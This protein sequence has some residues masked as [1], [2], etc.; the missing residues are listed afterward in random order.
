[1]TQPRTKSTKSRAPRND[2]AAS[3]RVDDILL[4]P[5]WTHRWIQLLL[6]L[7]AVLLVIPAI[8]VDLSLVEQ[9]LLAVC[10]IIAAMLMN[11]VRGRLI[12]VSIV[13]LS[14][15]TSLRYMYWRVTETLHFESVIDGVF[16][17][18]LLG[19]ELYALAMLL[20][21]YF[22]TV[23]PLRRKPVPLPADASAWPTV[24]VYIPTFSE[25]LSVVRQTVLA[26]ASLDWP[27]DRLRVYLLD[28]G[29]RDE[30]REFCEQ[31]GVNYLTRP[32]NLHAKAGNLNAA[33]RRTDGE[34]IAVFDCDHIVTRSFLQICMG[35]FLKDPKLGMLQTPHVFFSPD[36]FERNLGT[37]KNVP[38]EGEL[39]YGVV[40]DGNDLWNATFFCGSCAVMRREALEAVGGVATESVTEDAL[41]SLKMNR[42]GYDTAYLGVPQAAGLATESLSRHIGQRVRWARGMAEIFRN[43]NPLMGTGLKLSQR[44]CYLAAMLHFFFG[45]PRIVFLLTPM[46]YLFFGARVFNASALMVMTYALPHIVLSS[47]GGSRIQG[48]FRH[49][50]WNEVYETVLAWY[51]TVPSIQALLWPGSK[52]FNVTQKGGLIKQAFFDWALARPYIGLLLVNVAGMLTGIVLLMFR[53]DF[54]IVMT[55]LINMIWAF[56][57]VVITSAA[58]GVA[59]EERQLRVTPRVQIS[60][61][62]AIG[63]ADGRRIACLTSDFS[64]GGLGLVLPQGAPDVPRGEKVTVSVFRDDY[65]GIFPAEVSLSRG[66]SLGVSL[67]ALNIEQEKDL[68]RVTFGR[69]DNW[70]LSWG[71][72]K[73]DAPLESMGQ[74]ILIGMGGFRLLLRNMFSWSVV[75]LNS[76]SQA[77]AT[78]RQGL[79]QP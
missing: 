65:E 13:V 55:I 60:L 73:P 58:V 6:L 24:D 52:G 7:V 23:W 19:A 1:M 78:R 32:D 56:Y 35:W 70:A 64:Q 26:A 59:S 30:F 20:L 8:T 34:F 9:G 61:P 54:D 16:G 37:F 18:I 76:P 75:R 36:P 41:T 42:Q 38:N 31:V 63:L 57:N 40:Q 47:L 11:K 2:A 71:K 45:L 21:S 49:S 53:P 5:L 15:A 39:F 29:R 28:D 72:K 51:V 74:V 69:A 66:S 46:A 14:I 43:N 3:Q 44:F 33:L 12:T 48:S 62:A 79:K 10:C 67:L 17:Y 22:Q 77:K 25:P 50:F 68:S 4:L 27:A